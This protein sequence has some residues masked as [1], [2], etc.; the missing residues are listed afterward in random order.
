MYFFLSLCYPNQVLTMHLAYSKPPAVRDVPPISLKS[1]W[2]SLVLATFFISH[3][4]FLRLFNSPA[5]RLISPFAFFLVP[6]LVAFRCSLAIWIY[7][8]SEHLEEQGTICISGTVWVDWETMS[9]SYTFCN[10]YVSLQLFEGF[11]H[12]MFI[13]FLNRDEIVF[14]LRT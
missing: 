13:H 5:P 14:S 6:L 1:S 3:Q 8:C 10:F 11:Q 7:I 4:S 12:L 2:D 9:N